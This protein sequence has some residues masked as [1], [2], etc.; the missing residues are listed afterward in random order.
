DN[1]LVSGVYQQVMTGDYLDHLLALDYLKDSS[2]KN[3]KTYRIEKISSVYTGN[4]KQFALSKAM[5][6][7]FYRSENLEELD[8]FKK[9]FQPYL[10]KLTNKQFKE[11]L[12]TF[13]FK[14][15]NALVKFRTGKPAVN[16]TLEDMEGKSFSL[17]DF[18][19]K[20]V[21]LDFWASWC[22]SCRVET[23][24]LQA[25]YNKY[26]NDDRVVFISIAVNDRM[27]EWKKAI[28][29]DKPGW[30]QL[31]DKNDLASK[32][33]AANLIPKFILID[34]LGNIATFDAP[35]P[36]DIVNVTRLI[37]EEVKK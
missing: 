7:K 37:D 8:E 1:Y 24:H 10:D 16:F 20:A 17:A 5:E 25:L 19:G 11:K 21:Y 15:A 9:I 4:V 36:S 35:P 32:A 2:L 3:R 12:D 30:L 23:P 22:Y 31:K 13:Y 28:E 27:V 29:I 18:K 14:K 34:K 6:R 33:Y 26:K